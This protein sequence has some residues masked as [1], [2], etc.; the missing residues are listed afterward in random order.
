MEINAEKLAYW[1]FRLNGFLCFEN[2]IVHPNIG[3]NQRTEIDVLGVR[4]PY[5]CELYP[6]SP[7]EDDVIFSKVKVPYL[8]LADV[9]VSEGGFNKTW[10]NPVKENM[11]SILYAV[12][13]MPTADVEDAAKSLYSEG[14]YETS[15][16]F[17]SWFSICDEVSNGTKTVKPRVPQKTWHEVLEFIHNRFVTY[18]NSKKV[19]PQWKD[20]NIQNLWRLAISKKESFDNF[21][22][23]ICITN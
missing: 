6:S 22:A 17:I 8:V 20:I 4:F 5:R 9:T 10:K 15:D 14:F 2:F 23:E 19:H 1:Y 12:G 11:Q 3:S 7:M 21:R 13:L 16:F 18:E